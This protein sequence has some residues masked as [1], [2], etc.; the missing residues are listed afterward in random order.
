[1]GLR[2]QRLLINRE[3][4]RAAGRELLSAVTPVRAERRR[5]A[6]TDGPQ[7]K[8]RMRVRT[9]AGVPVRTEKV[10]AIS[11]SESLFRETDDQ[12]SV[13][14]LCAALEL[15]LELD[16]AA[17]HQPNHRTTLVAKYVTHILRATKRKKKSVST[18]ER[19]HLRRK[20]AARDGP[21]E[22]RLFSIDE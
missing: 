1:M 16:E 13:R 21:T 12:L 11:K 17:T 18:S 20:P 7:Q 10:T 15:E 14:V 3:R 8:E 4:R 2:V 5:L 9:I 19:W 6:R 22:P